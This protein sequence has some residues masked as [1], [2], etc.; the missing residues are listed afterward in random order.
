MDTLELILRQSNGALL[1]PLK[2]T[3]GLIGR[4]PQ[5]LRNQLNLG[6]CPLVPLKLGRSVFFQATE[7]A[8]LIDGLVPSAPQPRRGRPRKSE[9]R[10]GSAHQARGEK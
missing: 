7:I 6:T 4:E 3:A 5:T 8:A 2:K 10:S 9:V 1:V